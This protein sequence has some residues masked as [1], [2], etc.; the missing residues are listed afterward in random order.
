MARTPSAA[1][2]GTLLL[3]AES[4]LKTGSFGIQTTPIYYYS[5]WKKVM[6]A[7]FWGHISMMEHCFDTKPNIGRMYRLVE[8]F[9]HIDGINFY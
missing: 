3:L 1:S 6:D 8:H 2:V 5:L 4:F 9:Y 7:E